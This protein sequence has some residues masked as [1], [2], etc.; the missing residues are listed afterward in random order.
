MPKKKAVGGAESPAKRRK[1]DA[2]SAEVSSLLEPIR[3][4]QCAQAD[5]GEPYQT[6]C[7]IDGGWIVATD[8][9]LSAGHPIPDPLTACPH[10]YRLAD[11]LGRAKEAVGMTLLDNGQLHINAGRLKAHIDTLPLTALR[12]VIPDQN[13][14]PI[15]NAVRDAMAAVAPLVSDTAE[16]VIMASIYLANNVAAATNR[17]VIYEAWHG[18][19]LPSVVVPKKFSTAINKIKSDVIGFGYTEGNSITFWF[20]SGGWI[21]TQLYNETYPDYS[22]IFDAVQS[23]SLWTV[24]EGLYEGLAAVIPHSKNGG[25][26]FDGASVG[27]HGATFDIPGVPMERSFTGTHLAATDGIAETMD[28]TALTTH[29]EPCALFFGKVGEIPIRG[30]IMGRKEL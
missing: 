6:H 13:I 29:G 20:E 27:S 2:A 18:I 9:I 3:F 7:I 4:I 14:W 16:H 5:I 25:V 21:K 10:T 1:K 28:L 26:Y 30:I 23:N 8:G 19:G 15:T 12:P 11:V 24:P 17:M 22:R